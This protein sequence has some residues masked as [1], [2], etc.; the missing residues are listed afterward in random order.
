MRRGELRKGLCFSNETILLTTR[1]RGTKVKLPAPT[2][3]RTLAPP[4]GSIVQL[5]PSRD[6]PSL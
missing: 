4:R 1:R 3:L 6:A 5:G 2:P